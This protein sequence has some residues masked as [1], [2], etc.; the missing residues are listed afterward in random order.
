MSSFCLVLA[1]GVTRLL[2]RRAVL[3]SQKP[4][5]SWGAAGL[6][7]STILQ[8]SGWIF[9]SIFNIQ[10]L[11]YQS[12]ESVFIFLVAAGLAAAGAVSLA[13]L[14]SLGTTFILLLWVSHVYIFIKAQ[15]WPIAGL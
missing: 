15:A 2:A 6:K 8:V 7:Y 9:F 14:P 13:A 5:L 4:S 1:A 11:G 12:W 3:T 10:K